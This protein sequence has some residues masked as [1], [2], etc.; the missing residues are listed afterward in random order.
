M[1][2]YY[3]KSSGPLVVTLSGGRSL[4]LHGKAWS[5]V[6]P[7]DEGAEDLIAYLRKGFLVRFEHDK[8]TLAEPD[9]EA[10]AIKPGLVSLAVEPVDAPVVSLASSATKTESVKE[11]FEVEGFA[12]ASGASSSVPSEGS[13]ESSVNDKTFE[14]SPRRRRG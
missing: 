8:V 10:P 4:Y 7:E 13:E 14:T 2:E 9:A 6:S 11:P 3:N 1:A 5:T 12:A